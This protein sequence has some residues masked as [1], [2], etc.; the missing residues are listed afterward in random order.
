MT[1]VADTRSAAPT[2]DTVWVEQESFIDRVPRAV[3]MLGL[4][5]AFIAIWQLVV[6]SGIVSPII[7]SLIHI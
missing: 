4:F 3:S 5:G 6:W 7:L 1:S 2:P